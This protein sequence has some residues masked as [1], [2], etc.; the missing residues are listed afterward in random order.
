MIPQVWRCDVSASLLR[1]HPHTGLAA[2]SLPA[3]EIKPVKASA[4]LSSTGG[5]A[6]ACTCISGQL[7][8]LEPR[9]REQRAAMEA[10][11][12]LLRGGKAADAY[13]AR[14]VN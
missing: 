2:S 1:K 12:L 9:S 14:Q 6:P 10:P 7:F 5:S 13:W 8:Y 3:A 4:R 11:E